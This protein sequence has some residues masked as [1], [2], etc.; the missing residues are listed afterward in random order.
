MSKKT[1]E[2]VSENLFDETVSQ[3]GWGCHWRAMDEYCVRVQSE[4]LEMKEEIGEKQK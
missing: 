4:R 3:Y 1:K 2:I